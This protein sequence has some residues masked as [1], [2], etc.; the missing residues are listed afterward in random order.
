[1]TWAPSETQIAIFNTLAGDSAL[2]TLLGTTT[3]APKVYDSVP[4]QKSYPYITI[5][6]KPM[7]N[8]DN[9]DFDGVG[10]DYTVNVWSQDQAAQGDKVVQSIQKRIDEL[11][12]KQDICVMGWNVISHTRNMVDI[13]TDPDGRT[14]HGVQTFNLMLGES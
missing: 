12:H 5:H 9:E 13:Q 8:R 3:A 14:R 10:F 11:L 7:T 6:I 2:Q 1:M 4:D